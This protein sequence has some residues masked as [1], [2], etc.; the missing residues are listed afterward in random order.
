MFIKPFKI[1]NNLQLKGS[2]VKKLKSRVSAQYSSVNDDD[3][4]LLFP[5]KSSFS[6][7]KM[8]ISDESLVNVYA[9][10]KRPMFFEISGQTKLYPTLYAL[11][12]VPDLVPYFTTNSAVSITIS[13]L[14]KIE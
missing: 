13:S 12:S 7:M 5:N 10:D 2:E 8:E 9:K 3:L 11:W 6:M 1:K 14:M 4:N